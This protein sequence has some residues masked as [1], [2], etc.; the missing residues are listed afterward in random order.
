MKVLG[1]QKR[2]N[3]GDLEFRGSA[4][5]CMLWEKGKG[6]KETSKGNMGCDSGKTDELRICRM[7][8]NMYVPT[9]FI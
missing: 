2:R 1:E 6:E 3:L 9:W 5:L 8:G 7:T 4:R